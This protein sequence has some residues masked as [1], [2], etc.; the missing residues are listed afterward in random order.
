M[1]CEIHNDNGKQIWE[2][3]KGIAQFWWRGAIKLFDSQAG[4]IPHLKPGK[5]EE[6]KQAVVWTSS[7]SDGKWLGYVFFSF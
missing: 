7:T 4:K 2:L 5:S 3:F 1:Y 6:M